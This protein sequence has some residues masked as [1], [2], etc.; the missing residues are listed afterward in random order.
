MAETVGVSD[1]A[2]FG[3]AGVTGDLNGDGIVD[4]HDLRILL[5]S[6]GRSRGEQGFNQKADLDGNGR[7]DV[8]DLASLAKNFKPA[9]PPPPLPP[10]IINVVESVGV[11][12]N[13]SPP[14]PPAVIYI[15]ESIGVADNP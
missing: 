7:L 13:P 10:A 11:A 15:A 4:F 5:A 6:F 12:D 8:L 2:Q 9:P 3:A 14:P 1:S